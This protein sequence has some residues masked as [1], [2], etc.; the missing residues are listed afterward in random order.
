MPITDKYGQGISGLDYGDLP[1]LKV[2]SENLL[3]MVGQT[4]MR[5][6]SASA[7]NATL[8]SPVEGMATWLTSEARLE[9]YHGGSWLAWPPIPVQTFQVSDAPYNVTLT[10]VDYTSS[11]WPRPQFIAPPSGRAYVTISA[12]LTNTN[13]ATSTAWAAWRATGSLGFTFQ[14][15]NKTGISAQGA[16]VGASRRLMLTGMTAGETI[17]IIPQWNISSGSATTASTFGGSLLVE[18]AP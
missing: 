4:V 18:P 2:L 9:I 8:A 17:T 12:V 14:D 11:A 16:R 5:F 10:T 13:A 6:A 1:D 15:L 7:R 3:A